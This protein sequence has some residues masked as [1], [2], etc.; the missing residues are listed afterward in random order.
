MAGRYGADVASLW[1]R[2]GEPVPV[3]SSEERAGRGRRDPEGLTGASDVVLG[4]S[5][6][7]R[8]GA[9]PGLMDALSYPFFQTV[10]DRK[11]RRVGLGMTGSRTSLS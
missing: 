9:P 4:P 11:S 8:P 7:L 3:A 10:F 2:I 6:L 5:S 1:T